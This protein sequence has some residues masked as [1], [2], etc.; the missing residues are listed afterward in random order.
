M[1]A[2]VTV[3]NVTVDLNNYTCSYKGI[4]L[5]LVSEYT[6]SVGGRA[7][8][9]LVGMLWVFLA[10]AI[11]ADVFMCAIERI[12][13]KTTIVR[14]PDPNADGGVRVME[15][16]VWN[17][18]V[19]NLSLMALGT[20]APEILLSVI[21]TFGN[22]FLAGELGPGTIVGSA[23][24]NLLVISGIC[25]MAVPS[26]ETR[27]V[28]Q[29]K[30]YCVTA[31]FCIF[32]YV[33][34][35]IVLMASSPNIVE[36]WEAVVTFVFFI[37]LVVVSY[38][39]D[40][41][42][43]MG[44]K[45][46]QPDGA[47][48]F[49]LVNSSGDEEAQQTEEE[50]SE[51]EKLRRIARNL[52]HEV[53]DGDLTEAEAARLA[54]AKANENTSHNRL[55]YRVNATRMLAGGR[56]LIPKVLSNFQELYDHI[57]LAPQERMDKDHTPRG[58]DH[59]AGGTKAVVEFTAAAI[60]VLE[61]EGK[62]RIGLRRYGK[63]EIP[64]TVH[65]ETINGT[66]LA[67]EDYKHFSD[68][69]K[70]AQHEELRQI[71]I[72]IVDDM[73][74]EPDEFFFVKLSIPEKEDGSHKHIAIGDI[75]INQVTIID[76]DEPGKLEFARPSL[77]VKE[78]HYVARIP[79]NR[80]NGCDGHVSVKWITSDIT[81][82][83]GTDYTGKE[84][85][86]VFDN[87]ESNKTIDIPLFESKKKE[88]DECFAIE[89]GECDGGAQVGKI[90]KCIVSIVNDEDFD[91]IVSRLMNMT[92]ANI[93]GMALESSTWL[94]QFHDAMNV[95]GG[96]TENAA[97]IDYVLH[98]LSFGWKIIFAFIPPAKYLGGWPTFWVSLAIIG[99][100]T[101]IINDLAATFGCLIGLPD[102]ITAITFVALGTS[103]PDTFAS[104]TAA[105]N[106]KTADSSVGNVN[107]SNS[108]NVFLGLG[109][110][111]LISSIYW[112]V[113]G[114]Q[115]E[116]PAGSMGFSVVVYVVVAL[117]ALALLAVRRY[118]VAFGRAEL[119]GP[120]RTKVIS[121]VFLIFLWLIYVILSSLQATGTINVN[122]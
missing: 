77:V 15:V 46:R 64:C 51:N 73:E 2:F 32:A 102:A 78:S 76:D 42:F 116:V 120:Q 39:A 22:G 65:V 3:D 92:K 4:I 80:V 56:R 97:F 41:N 85:L 75:S 59:T 112:A 99:I 33:W 106:E 115:F 10:V 86:L 30:V 121:G 79:V 9:Y 62:V 35:A 12:T 91:G 23:A 29:I 108:V 98:F 47:V 24:F 58:N 45:E 107:G 88:R 19:A 27:R 67:N 70:F 74:W 14:V 68:D 105:M 71:Y 81:A 48:G 61:N 89:L 82:K 72:E 8:L 17:N 110:P 20:S 36:V 66:A 122:F 7:F 25:I 50:E 63:T 38:L 6:W 103:M 93:G 104:K 18:T 96:D 11:I 109:L 49:A 83:E 16:K 28:K 60:S 100:L 55:W 34:M 111:W 1:P 40:R 26:P 5:P 113:K 101:A 53:R 57:Q 95:N 21:E 119:G 87:Q 43:C 118:S 52:S 84:G 114:K 69:V 54:I 37:I 13:S 117:M 90:K 44:E 31:F 94:Q